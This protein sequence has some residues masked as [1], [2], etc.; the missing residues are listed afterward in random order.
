MSEK[1][2]RGLQTLDAVAYALVVTALVFAIGAGAAAATGR[3][4][5]VGGKRVMF[6]V[7]FILLGYSAFQLRP[8]PLWK[9]DGETETERR[10]P[11][12]IQAAVARVMPASIRLAPD[13][14]LSPTAKLFIASVLVLATSG[15]MELVGVVPTV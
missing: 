13:E 12:G 7:G 14:R 11:V 10:R 9:R 1:R 15:V 3:Q 5:L 4:P 6:F 8:T 2:R